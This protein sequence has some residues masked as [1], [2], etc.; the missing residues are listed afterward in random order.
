MNVIHVLVED[1][2]Y[3]L[4]LIKN[5]HIFEP[6]ISEKLIS[7]SPTLVCMR[8]VDDT[9]VVIDKNCA[10]QFTDRINSLVPHIK[11]TNNPKKDRT[12]PF[13]DTLVKCQVDGSAN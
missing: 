8:Y 12:F 7:F 9:F 2:K 13:L 10:Q 11:L 6:N 5:T 1:I 4:L 3:N